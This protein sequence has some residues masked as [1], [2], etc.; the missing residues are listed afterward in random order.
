MYEN[1]DTTHY[2]YFDYIDVDGNKKQYEP[3]CSSPQRV[4]TVSLPIVTHPWNW[5]MPQVREP[6]PERRATRQ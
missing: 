1:E 5:T 3:I 6:V 2:D 4:T